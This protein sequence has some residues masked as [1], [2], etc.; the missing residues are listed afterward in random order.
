MEANSRRAKGRPASENTDT[1]PLL[2]RMHL[3]PSVRVGLLIKMVVV[4]V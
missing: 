4:I 3:P 2:R 1:R